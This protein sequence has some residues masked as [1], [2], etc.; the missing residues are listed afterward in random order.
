MS[1]LFNALSSQL[2]FVGL[3]RLESIVLDVIEPDEPGFCSSQPKVLEDLVWRD[4]GCLVG[5]PV[6]SA[7]LVLPLEAVGVDGRSFSLAC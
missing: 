1:G 6:A 5:L 2:A 4:R 3:Q 7:R